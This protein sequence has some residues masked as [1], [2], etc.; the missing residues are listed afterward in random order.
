MIDLSC[1]NLYH[2]VR[3]V[4]V[5]GVQHTLVHNERL[6]DLGTFIWNQS[7]ASH[8]SIEWQHRSWVS[9]M[10]PFVGG[11]ATLNAVFLNVTHAIIQVGLLLEEPHCFILFHLSKI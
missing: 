9:D 5:V 1:R 3:M 11:E 7:L 8:Q 10:S 6:P 2:E 4:L